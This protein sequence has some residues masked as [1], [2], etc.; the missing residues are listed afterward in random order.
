MIL[1][2]RQS[3]L[4]SDSSK[5]Y[6]RDYEIIFKDCCCKI[7]SF[8]D[9]L[10]HAMTEVNYLLDTENSKQKSFHSSQLQDIYTQASVVVHLKLKHA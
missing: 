2:S 1:T 8:L 9:N 4:F 6:F 10:E 5:C 3:N 7:V